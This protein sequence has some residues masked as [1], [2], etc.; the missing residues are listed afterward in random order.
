MSEELSK[1]AKQH[2][3]LLDLTEEVKQLKNEIKQKYMK[4]E[5]LE[6]RLDDLEQ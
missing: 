1:V 3:S 4:M 5:K 6:Q 2:R